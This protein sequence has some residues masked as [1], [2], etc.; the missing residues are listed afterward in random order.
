[1]QLIFKTF[2]TVLS[3]I[4]STNLGNSRATGGEEEVSVTN[5]LCIGH[6]DVK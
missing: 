1:M 3:G 4:D 2:V 5:A 6:I